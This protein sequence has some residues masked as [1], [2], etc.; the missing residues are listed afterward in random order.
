M[1]KHSYLQGCTLSDCVCSILDILQI[2]NGG[3]SLEDTRGAQPLGRI[4]SSEGFHSV[5]AGRPN[6]VI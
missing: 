2:Q 4:Q 5:V 3:Q 1:N 6:L